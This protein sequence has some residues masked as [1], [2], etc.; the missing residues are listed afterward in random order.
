MSKKN[1]QKLYQNNVALTACLTVE[2]ILVKYFKVQL[3][4]GF[5]KCVVVGIQILLKKL[6]NE[7]PC[8]S[9]NINIYSF[10]RDDDNK[11]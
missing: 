8:I 7:I 6:S 3:I 11:T 1:I 4:R 5:L 9:K 10:V 2:N